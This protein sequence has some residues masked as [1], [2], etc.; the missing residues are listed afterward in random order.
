MTPS[1]T[2]ALEAACI[3]CLE[4]GDEVIM[5]S[6]AFPSCT[7]AIILR[8]AKPV[9]VDVDDDLNIDLLL[10]EEALTSKTKAVMVIHYAGVVHGNIASIKELCD[11]YG[12]YLIEDAAQAIG[13]W[14]LTG[15]FGCLSFH[16]TK[17]VSC[18]Q[19]GALIVQDR[20]VE[21]TEKVL[22]CGT[23]KLKFYRGEQDHYSWTTV[24]SQYVMSGYLKEILLP[25]LERIEE[26]TAKRLKIWNIYESQHGAKHWSSAHN[27]HFY[28]FMTDN[29]WEK[30]K[31]WRKMGIKVTSHFEALHNTPIGRKYKAHYC[32]YSLTAER[33]LLK[34]DTS[35]TEDEANLA[36]KIIWHSNTESSPNT[37]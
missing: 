8:G 15:D 31:E 33:T 24:G 32:E 1:C 19:G 20:H 3:M 9:F 23:D 7:N 36:G 11:K 35:V 12:L 27:G 16:A 30:M 6:W 10:I 5:P 21:L 2:A 18:D 13:V 22:H 28:W 17:N 37:L 25:Q 34:L 14:K 4:P 29:K 26:I